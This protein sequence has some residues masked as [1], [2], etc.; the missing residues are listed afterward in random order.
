MIKKR[1]S[2]NDVSKNSGKPM[3]GLNGRPMLELPY[4]LE[5]FQKEITSFKEE[6]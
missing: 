4:P 5:K 2:L 3:A 6:H 1:F